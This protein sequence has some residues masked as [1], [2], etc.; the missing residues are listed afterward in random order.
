MFSMDIAILKIN[1]AFMKE[2]WCWPS[3]SVIYK[4]QKTEG[5]FSACIL[6][7]ILGLRICSPKQDPHFDFF[8]AL[9]KNE[10]VQWVGRRDPYVLFQKHLQYCTLPDDLE[11]QLLPYWE[12][13][14]RPRRFWFLLD[15]V[16]ITAQVTANHPRLTKTLSEKSWH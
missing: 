12:H 14:Q 2:L 1:N 4:L 11:I 6:K 10:I 13:G 5:W 3:C 9:G 8:V 7:C 16:K 15:G